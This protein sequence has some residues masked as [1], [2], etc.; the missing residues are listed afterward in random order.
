MF[1]LSSCNQLVGT[2]WST[3]SYLAGGLGDSSEKKMVLL[4]QYFPE[5]TT[6]GAF[7][8]KYWFVKARNS[9]GK[10]NP[11]IFNLN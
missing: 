4:T 8:D 7:Q 2:S 9:C 11:G 3:F 10:V 5:N 6:N 1:V